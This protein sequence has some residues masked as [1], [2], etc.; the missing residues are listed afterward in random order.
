MMDYIQKLHNII[1]YRLLISEL[2]VGINKWG[3]EVVLSANIAVYD[4]SVY[5]LTVADPSSSVYDQ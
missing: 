2:L 1:F 3:W 4:L 5:I